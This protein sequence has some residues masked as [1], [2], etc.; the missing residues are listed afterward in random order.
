M[1]RSTRCKERGTG[2]IGRRSIRF[3][4]G[5]APVLGGRPDGRMR[6]KDED[7]VGRDR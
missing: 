1:D 3:D 7:E 2:N 6:L 5:L 4:L